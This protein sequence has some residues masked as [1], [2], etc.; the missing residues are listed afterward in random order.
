LIAV[1]VDNDATYDRTK[2]IQAIGACI[3][4]ILLT[5]HFLGLGACWLGEILKQKEKIARILDVPLSFE[6]MAV[7]AIGYPL[8]RERT[9][10]RRPLRELI[11]KWIK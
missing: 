8:I 4:N 5:A 2:D 9:G 7:L 1:F 3:E 11:F 10:S 6:L